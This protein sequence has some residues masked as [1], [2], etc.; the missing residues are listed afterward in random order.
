MVAATVRGANLLPTGCR[1]DAVWCAWRNCFFFIFPS[2]AFVVKIDAV[3]A[4]LLHPLGS[5]VGAIICF[6]KP[7]VN[8]AKLLAERRS[9]MRPR[10]GACFAAIFYTTNDHEMH[11]RIVCDAW[12]VTCTSRLRVKPAGSCQTCAIVSA[13]L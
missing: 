8:F 10:H 11:S 6:E 4:S 3:V 13:R 2:C 5:D 7:S 1:H 12:Q 9:L